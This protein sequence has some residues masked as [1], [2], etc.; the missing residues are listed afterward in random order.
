MSFI[1]KP[2]R[3]D[4]SSDLQEAIVAPYQSGKSF[5]AISKQFEVHHSTARRTVQ[6]W[7]TVKGVTSLPRSGCPS[8]FRPWSEHVMFRETAK[9]QKQ[10]RDASQTLQASVGMLKFKV[11]NR[12]IILACFTATGQEHLAVTE[13][14]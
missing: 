12:V 4:I 7:K 9:N 13:S 6:K 2:I 10:N 11:L 14:P 5:Q 8:Q 3:K 1:T